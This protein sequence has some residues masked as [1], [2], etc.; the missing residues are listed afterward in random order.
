M[1]EFFHLHHEIQ[2]AQHLTAFVTAND[3]QTRILL[4]NQQFHRLACEKT[5][6]LEKN[7]A[8]LYTLR[9]RL[10]SGQNATEDEL[11][12][13]G[14]VKLA[15]VTISRLQAKLEMLYFSITRRV[16]KISSLAGW[17]YYLTKL[18]VCCLL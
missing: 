9:S 4:G 5:K 14:K 11:L 16:K 18:T 7:I 1:A 6:E 2:N 15:K 8:K 10:L 13:E 3:Y 12:A 17:Y